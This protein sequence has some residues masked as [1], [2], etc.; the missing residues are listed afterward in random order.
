[1]ITINFFVNNA[2]SSITD[3][4]RDELQI[5]NSSIEPVNPPPIVSC[6]H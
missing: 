3:L 6:E 4:D 1:M 2:W 5:L